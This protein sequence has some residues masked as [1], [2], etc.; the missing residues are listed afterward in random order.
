[1]A[2]GGRERLVIKMTSIRVWDEM[3]QGERGVW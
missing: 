3:P 1:M 2:M